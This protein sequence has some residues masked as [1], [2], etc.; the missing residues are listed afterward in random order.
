MPTAI[1]RPIRQLIVERHEQG[2]TLNEIATTLRLSYW[3]VRR[4]WRQYRQ[5]GQAG[6]ET[7]YA[8]CGHHGVR[9]ERQ[10]YRAAIWLKRRHPGW[11]AGLIRV[12]LAQR[13]SPN[14]LP[15]ERTL[16]RWF[17]QAGVQ[18]SRLRHHRYR[19]GEQARAQSVHQVWQLD[20]T[21]HMHLADGSDASWLS[22][23]DEYS[24]A[25]LD[26]IVF[27]PVPI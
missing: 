3:S 4:I 20:A 12:I 13:Y 19:S 17:V 1:E 22:V 10:I 11:G 18:R 25:L 14:R 2:T 6:L 24:G 7:R 5:H 23:T 9:S 26:S 15:H 8:R 16:Q 21:S 27:P